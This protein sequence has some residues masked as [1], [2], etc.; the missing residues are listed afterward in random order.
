MLDVGVVSV[1][2]IACLRNN[3]HSSTQGLMAAGSTAPGLTIPG[4]SMAKGFRRTFVERCTREADI[5]FSI[6][7]TRHDWQDDKTCR[8]AGL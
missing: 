4:S 5:S 2:G 6:V 3:D 1:G 7:A 8:V